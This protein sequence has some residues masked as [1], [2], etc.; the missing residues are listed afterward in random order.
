MYVE[1]GKI[2]DR[3]TFRLFV[4]DLLGIGT[5]LLP[6]YLAKLT[7]V[8]GIFA[9]LL[10]GIGGYIYLRYLGFI[11]GTIKTDAG[12]YLQ[13]HSPK[14]VQW[15]SFGYL[16]LHSILTA[17]F[18]AYVF[19]NLMQHSLIRKESFGVIL[20]VTMLLS[21]YAI[22]GGIESRARVY[23]VL[24]WFIFIPYVFMMLFSIRDVKMEYFS[25]F[26]DTTGSNFVKGT[27]LVF[28]LLTPLFF[29]I[30]LLEKRNTSSE[31]F[32]SGMIKIVSKSLLFSIV[33]F[34]GSYIILLGC[35]GEQGLS[36]MRY[37]VITLMSTVQF[38][39]SFLKRMDALMLGVWFFTLFALIN[40]HL[41]YGVEMM[42]K[43]KTSGRMWEIGIATML[44]YITAYV[45]EQSD[46]FVNV[47]LKYYSYVAVPI[48]IFGP[49]LLL[50]ANPHEKQENMKNRGMP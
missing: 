30:F 6:P 42:N 41:H 29:S 25:S 34:L 14:W 40:L 23:E 21:A 7:G 28:L 33:V 49:L 17:G 1:N 46:G 5:L 35:F 31:K 12:S 19:T 24:F 36:A 38:R 32:G 22:G 39:G 47:F 45:M 43:I 13:E 15:I 44:V 11:I 3:Q 16:S 18:C 4:F 37:P 20:L 2:S 8:D 50:W 48:M 27:Y 26:F 10:G 9:I